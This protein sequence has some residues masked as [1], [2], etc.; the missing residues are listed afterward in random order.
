MVT[1]LSKAKHNQEITKPHRIL[2]PARKRLY[3]LKEAA[4]YLGRSEWS[5]RELIWSGS[6]PVVRAE[7]GRKIFLDIEDL[8]D[9]INRNKSIY[10]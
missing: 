3:T 6:I 1:P 4:E 5:M 10:L 9:F 7:G 2:N 8:N